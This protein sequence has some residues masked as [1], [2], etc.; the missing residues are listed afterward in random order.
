MEDKKINIIIVD[1]SKVF[2]NIFNDYM[3]SKKDI[4][5]TGIANNGL[6]GLRL[7]EEKKPDLVILDIIMPGLDG[8]GVLEK[9]NTMNLVPFPRI[10]MLSAFGQETIAQ[11]AISLGAVCYIVKPF[12]MELLIKKVRET[13]N[14]TTYS[15]MA[16]DKINKNQPV[17]M[18][19][20][21]NNII[22]EIGIPAHLKGCTYVKEAI[23]MVVNNMELLSAA[24]DDL[25]PLISKRHNTTAS[26]VERS[27]NHSIEVT[28]SNVPLQ[29]INKI[30]GYSIHY[31]KGSPNNSEFIAMVAD[32]L[33]LQNKIS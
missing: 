25:Y 27:I 7:I 11:K 10:I 8:L 31:K 19:V 4:I 21:I 32:K 23:S 17:D 24:T 15:D 5:V 29:I 16:E 6:E 30:F 12:D 14:I 3:L 22:D 2:C 26:R 1:D 9:L 28:W 13:S 18:I 33:I 20:Q